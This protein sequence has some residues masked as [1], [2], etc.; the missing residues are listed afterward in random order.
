MHSGIHAGT[1]LLSEGDIERGRYDL[2]GD[3]ASTA[4]HL[5]RHAAPGQVLASLDALG[6][7]ATF[8]ELG[9]APRSVGEK[10]GLPRVYAVLARGSASRRFEATPAGA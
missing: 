5:S 1:L 8:F 3:V 9:E 10:T 6:P 2:I 4:A 7:H